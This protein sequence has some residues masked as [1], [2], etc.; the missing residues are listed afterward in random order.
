MLIHTVTKIRSLLAIAG[1]VMLLSG[2]V[3]VPD[4]IKGNS[5]TPVVDLASVQNAPSMFSGADARF[6][7]KVISVLNEQGKTVLEIAAAPLDAGARP[8]LGEPSQGRLLA[9]VKGFLEPSDFRGH[10]VTVVGP[11]TGVQQGKIGTTPYKFVTMDATGFKRWR[12][13]QQIVMPPA[14]MGPWGWRSGPWG[15]GWGAGYG[16]YNPGPAQVQT[17]VTE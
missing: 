15:P 8:I 1:G 12:L 5:P 6:G 9:S 2:C 4:V 17:I 10:L 16:W 11:I 14:P 7:G 3:T 13:A